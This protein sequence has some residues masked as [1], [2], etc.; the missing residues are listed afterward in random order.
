MTK[1]LYQILDLEVD[2]SQ[3]EIKKSYRLLAR[4][5]HPDKHNGDKIFEDKFKEIKDAYDVLIDPAK[6]K[7]YDYS[8]SG[9]NPR[10]GKPDQT[11]TWATENKEKTT[12]SNGDKGFKR[13]TTVDPKKKGLNDKRSRGCL[14]GIVAGAVFAITLS[15]GDGWWV[16]MG[17]VGLSGL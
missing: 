6:R 9:H 13:T 12:S 8:F 10:K 14:I 7:K 4:K 3:E 5:Y 16:P 11:Y 15:L 2:A 1:N 17:V